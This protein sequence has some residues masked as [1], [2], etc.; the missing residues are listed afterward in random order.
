MIDG[1]KIRQLREALGW[2]QAELA[3]R[4]RVR[5]PTIATIEQ[6]LQR[7]SRALP[8]I[9]VALGVRV[10]E[11]DPDYPA[12]FSRT[13]GIETIDA[14]SALV[15]FEVILGYLRPDLAHE[16][17]QSLARVWLDLALEPRDEKI[18]L[19]LAAQMRLRAQ[20]LVRPFRQK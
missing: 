10:D 12:S 14:T 9:A 11:I 6:G 13:P 17:V 5:Q 19:D 8:R 20:F 18:E 4:S 15:A 16:D 3:R 7:T 2:S 1:G